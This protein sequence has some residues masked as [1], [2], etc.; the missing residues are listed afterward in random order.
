MDPIT[1]YLELTRRRPELFVPSEHFPLFLDEVTLRRYAAATGRPVGVVYDNSPYYLVLADLCLDAGGPYTYARVI[2]PHH[3][4]GAVVIPRR[5]DRFGL[6]SIFR[7]PTRSESGGEFPRGFSEGHSP[8]ETA[9]RELE[10][11]L[12]A[13]VDPDDLEYLGDVQPDTGLSSGRVQVFLARVDQAD[14][15]DLEDEEDWDR[16]LREALPS[17]RRLGV[18]V[19]LSP[20][21]WNGVSLS[22]YCLEWWTGSLSGAAHLLLT[23]L[24][25][26]AWGLLLLALDARRR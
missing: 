22:V 24:L 20:L 4:S 6:L 10:E 5:G 18:M 17:L 26:A 14:W 25:T 3:S 23:W 16:A 15:D 19:L 13:R 12:G 1:Q 8:A 11:E 7:H 2:Y 9:A 21:I